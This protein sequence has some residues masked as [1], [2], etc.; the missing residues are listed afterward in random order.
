MKQSSKLDKSWVPNLSRGKKPMGEDQGAVSMQCWL[1]LSKQIWAGTF[2]CFMH[3]YSALWDRE[4]RDERVNP[5]TNNARSSTWLT[6]CLEEKEAFPAAL[7]LT[8]S[9]VRSAKPPTAEHEAHTSKSCLPPL[10][11]AASFTFAVHQGLSSPRWSHMPDLFAGYLRYLQGS[12]IGALGFLPQLATWD[13]ATKCKPQ[14]DTP[15]LAITTL[16]WLLYGLDT[17]MR[18][19]TPFP[20]SHLYYNGN[21][22]EGR[23]WRAS[24]L[25]SLKNKT[26]KRPFLSCSGVNGA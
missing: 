17:H 11:R 8:R 4:R 9:M 16:C 2:L 26:N 22:D 15:C 6:S 13:E 21:Q 23:L 3:L 25:Q 1:S 5:G 14:P 10:P 7:H 19:M 18:A 20:S 24:Y 12:H